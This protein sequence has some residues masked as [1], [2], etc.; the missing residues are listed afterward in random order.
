MNSDIKK[1]NEALDR[2][3][4][5]MLAKFANL[6]ELR[7]KYQKLQVEEFVAIYKREESCAKCDKPR[8]RHRYGK[9]SHPFKRKDSLASFCEEFGPLYP[10]LDGAGHVRY[11]WL[12]RGVWKARSKGDMQ[13]ASDFIADLYN[14]RGTTPKS[15]DPEHPNYR[16]LLTVD[17]ADG[18]LRIE[19]RLT[20]LDLMAGWLTVY[21]KYLATCQW[22]KC[23]RYF[24]KSGRHARYRY[25]SPECSHEAIIE[26]HRRS[27]R[28]SKSKANKNC[29]ATP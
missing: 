20:L 19:P 13:A 14:R 17:F 8:E 1:L 15:N 27:Y 10:G 25:C 2:G 28:K 3:P 9:N 4:E 24:V 21:R 5:Y 18:K 16:S 23:R 12:F 11:L 29:A 6:P 22:D 7:P 26:N